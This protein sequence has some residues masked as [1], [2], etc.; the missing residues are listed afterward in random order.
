MTKKLAAGKE[1]GSRFDPKTKTAV[2]DPA[3]GAEL[4][5]QLRNLPF[6]LADLDALAAD[7]RTK[8]QGALAMSA[9][10]LTPSDQHLLEM[11]LGHKTGMQVRVVYTKGSQAHLVAFPWPE[12]RQL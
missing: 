3:C 5:K 8:R 4:L 2:L 9:D 6:S 7:L 10:S 11:E 1:P 12:A